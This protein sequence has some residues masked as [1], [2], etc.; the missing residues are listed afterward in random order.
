MIHLLASC[1][2]EETRNVKSERREE[3]EGRR[4]KERGETLY[5]KNGREGRKNDRK[6]G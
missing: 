3:G 5:D 6:D 2:N 4:Q 1:V